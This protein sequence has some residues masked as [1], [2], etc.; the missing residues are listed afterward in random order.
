MS[1]FFHGTADP[2]RSE[3]ADAV[4]VLELLMSRGFI[5]NIGDRGVRDED[6]A[7]EYIARQREGYADNGYCL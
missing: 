1:D 7:R 4:F 3:D 5:D 6:G 2:Q